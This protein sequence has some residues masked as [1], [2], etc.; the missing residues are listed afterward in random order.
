M[1]AVRTGQH[2]HVMGMVPIQLARFL[3]PFKDLEDLRLLLSTLSSSEEDASRFFGARRG[4]FSL[5]AGLSLVAHGSL[6]GIVLE[7]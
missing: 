2:L 5:T 7:I 4:C 3:V 6:R 1:R